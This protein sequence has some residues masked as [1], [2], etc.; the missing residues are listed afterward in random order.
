MSD[1]K[2]CE[3]QPIPVAW[4]QS[5]R[6]IV[7]AF[8]AGD[9]RLTSGVANVAPIPADKAVHIQR[10]IK[11]YGAKLVQLPE[12]TWHSSVCILAGNHWDALVDLWTH[13]E[14]RSDMVL[15]A[16]VVA[17]PEFAVK[18]HLVYVP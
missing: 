6:E 10:Y 18:V 17:D 12:E 3:Q 16:R 13:E 14:G 15:H 4:R 9:Y 1:E 2:H 8:I 5:F 7:A 11:D